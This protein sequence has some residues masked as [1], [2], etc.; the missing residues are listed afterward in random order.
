MRLALMDASHFSGGDVGIIDL[1][2]AA[3]GSGIDIKNDT[4]ASSMTMRL[5]R[6][7]MMSSRSNVT[8][9]LPFFSLEW[10]PVTDS[11]R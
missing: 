2:L 5:R 6:S 8:M 4:C 3:S 11:T 10:F 7:L 9:C 1:R